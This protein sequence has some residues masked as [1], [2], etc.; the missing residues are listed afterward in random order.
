MKKIRYGVVGLGRMGV[1][2]TNVLA[3][4]NEIEFVGVFDLNQD[5]TKE[6]SLKYNIQGFSSLEALLAEV[7]ALSLCA[8]TSLHYEL[9]KK[10]LEAQKHV[11]IEK[12][13]TTNVKQAEELIFLAKEKQ[14]LL[15]VGHV[16][17]FNGAVQELSHVVEDPLLWESR[18]LGPPPERFMDTGVVMD[19]MI[20]DLDI[21]FRV[22]KDEIQSIKAEGNYLPGSKQ[23]DLATAQIKFKKGCVANFVASRITQEKIRTL[24][25]S[26]KQSYLLLDFTTQ[27]LQITRRASEA[28]ITSSE[29]IR[30]RQEALIERLFIHKDNP[31]RSE[32]LY[33]IKEIGH[34]PLNETSREEAYQDNTE[35]LKTLKAAAEIV[36]QIAESHGIKVPH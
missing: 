3:N 29:K 2:H 5:R 15:H 12:P 26:Q 9:G 18:R 32:L 19:L 13:L 25:I 34:S 22:V 6:I 31:L 8:P 24:A 21:C 11:L 14:R 35:D 16:E 4:I 23:E 30:Y 36:A 7:D 33:F 20:H 1:Y 10:I 28:T 17:R 27:D